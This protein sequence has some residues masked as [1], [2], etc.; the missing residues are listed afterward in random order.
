M[1]VFGKSG[2]SAESIELRL[3]NSAHGT[4]AFLEFIDAAFRIDELS[5]ARKEWM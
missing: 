5:E 1:G 4:E 2:D 3:P